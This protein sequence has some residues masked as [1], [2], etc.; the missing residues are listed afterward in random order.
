MDDA[1]RQASVLLQHVFTSWPAGVRPKLINHGHS[2]TEVDRWIL[3][4]Q[5]EVRAMSWHV[6]IGVGVEGTPYW[7]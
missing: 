5:E 6:Y 4:M 2:E 3:N 1:E 7:R